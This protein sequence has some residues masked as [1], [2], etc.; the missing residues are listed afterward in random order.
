VIAVNGFAPLWLSSA[1]R[2]Q[3]QRDRGRLDRDARSLQVIEGKK[4]G[5]GH[6]EEA[7]TV[8][9][10]RSIAE[11]AGQQRRQRAASAERLGEPLT[12][13]QK[14]TLIDLIVFATLLYGELP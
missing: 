9:F 5:D 14:E 8:K 2:S 12:Y 11:K 10:Q 13:V 7:E 3:P 6:P 1:V 4:C